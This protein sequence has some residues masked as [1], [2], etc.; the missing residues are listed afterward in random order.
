M[1]RETGLA[2]VYKL[3]ITETIVERMISEEIFS[4]SDGVLSFQLQTP[5][6]SVEISLSV[7]EAVS[8]SS[9][10]SADFREFCLAKAGKSRNTFLPPLFSLDKRR[11][12]IL[13]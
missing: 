13:Q 8:V 12:S 1:V 2:P 5:S 9:I 4:L 6:S 3:P 11:K 7:W 10:P